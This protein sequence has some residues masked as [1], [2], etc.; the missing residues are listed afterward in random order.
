MCFGS[1]VNKTDR[2]VK[3]LLDDVRIYAQELDE[4]VEARLER[5][6]QESWSRRL[7]AGDATLWTG[8]EEAKWLGWLAAGKGE[9]IDPEA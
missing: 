2:Q 3:G 4:A 8:G 9:Q 7:W 6:R 1:Q 5:M